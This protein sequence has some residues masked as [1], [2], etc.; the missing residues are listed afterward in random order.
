MIRSTSALATTAFILLGLYGCGAPQEQTTGREPAS[1]TQATQEEAPYVT[2]STEGEAP[3]ITLKDPC[4]DFALNPLTGAVAAIDPNANTFVIVPRTCLDGKDKKVI[5]PLRVGAYPQSIVYKAYRG[6]AYFIVACAKDNALYVM[7]AATGREVAKI[8]TKHD[9]VCKVVASGNDADPYI[10][11]GVEGASRPY[12]ACA[13]LE[14]LKD[15]GKLAIEE[16]LVDAA[17]S[18]DGEFLYCRFAFTPGLRVYRRLRNADGQATWALLHWQRQ[19][20]GRFMPDPFNY[21]TATGDRRIYTAD[22]RRSVTTLPSEPMCF[23]PDR[24]LLIGYQHYGAVKGRRPEPNSLFA[25]SCATFEAF[26]SVELR[27]MP[28]AARAFSSPASPFKMP[29]LQRRP[30]GA[31][32]FAFE[33]RCLADAAADRVV[34]CYGNKIAI[35]PLKALHAPKEPVLAVRGSVPDRASVGSMLTIQVPPF[36]IEAAV[37]L[38]EGPKGMKFLDKEKMLLW[39][40]AA[41]QVGRARF[42]LTISAKGISVEQPFE[43]NV[44]QPSVSLS[45]PV[46]GLAMSPKGRLAAAFSVPSNANDPSQLAL[47]DLD[48]RQV[49]CQK[50]LLVRLRAAALDERAVYVAPDNSDYIEALSLKDLSAGKRVNTGDVVQELQLNSKVLVAA[51]DQGISAFSL[52]DLKKLD[53]CGALPKLPATPRGIGSASP[54]AGQKASIVRCHDGWAYQGLFIS[55]DFGRI[56]AILASK[57]L[58]RLPRRGETGAADLSPVRSPWGRNVSGYQL[59]TDASQAVAKLPPRAG[60][61]VLRDLPACAGVWMGRSGDGQFI[62]HRLQVMDLLQGRLVLD[63]VLDER[64]SDQGYTSEVQ[65]QAFNS[66]R[67]SLPCAGRRMAIALGKEVFI[68]DFTD[69]VVNQLAAP[70]EIELPR[71]VPVLTAGAPGKV[72][73]KLRGGKEP[74]EFDLQG[75]LSELSINKATG[76]ITFDTT[77]LSKRAADAILG[78]GDLPEQV[79][80]ANVQEARATWKAMTGRG[81][82]A[83][84]ILVPVTVVA[85]DQSGQLATLTFH[86]AME[87]PDELVEGII[88]EAVASAARRQQQARKDQEARD[89]KMIEAEKARLVR[90]GLAPASRPSSQR[91]DELEKRITELEG[92]ADTLI[93]LLRENK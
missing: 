78:S 22:L 44:S 53:L 70:P 33:F 56:Q 84:P 26:G 80:R 62:T 85:S 18:A 1:V 24:P 17:V 20:Q 46:D 15:E 2:V 61:Q 39:T 37:E 81:T 64:M 87:L 12:I 23:F 25:F 54:G 32:P 21:L 72:E 77:A 6:K 82:G 19:S 40:P 45:F 34:A 50:R 42:A 58:P 69:E 55:E 75:P 88:R 38:K 28:D 65:E 7:D 5:G 83:L 60:W 51:C 79:M 31:R 4:C 74:L 36:S 76:V 66:A 43:L 91:L 30:T 3:T 59:Q 14:T 16:G 90:L 67:R 73:I 29:V 47:I 41:D 68:T 92:K 48:K 9:G 13:N 27:G 93:K 52:T 71:E 89:A 35:V 10:Y 86:A 57:S 63:Q 11:Y 8:P 49:L